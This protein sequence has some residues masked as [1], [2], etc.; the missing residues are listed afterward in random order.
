MRLGN[1]K[2]RT[3]RG[4]RSFFGY[5]MHVAMDQGSR[6]IRRLA[7][8]PANVNDTVPADGL[9]CGD[10]A[11]VYADKAYDSKAARQQIKDDGAVPVIPSRS[12]V[13]VIPT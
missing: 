11:T 10:E 3:D 8:T 9:I 4:R 6:I 2:T 1:G 12:F 5:K 13:R 7:F